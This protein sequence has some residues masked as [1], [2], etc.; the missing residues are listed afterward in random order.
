[1]KHQKNSQFSTE[2][3]W[4]MLFLY[5]N[6]LLLGG[7]FWINNREMKSCSLKSFANGALFICLYAFT[8][9]ALSGLLYSALLLIKC[10]NIYV[11]VRV[12][13]CDRVADL[14]WSFPCPTAIA[15][16]V[17][18]LVLISVGKHIIDTIL[19]EDALLALFHDIFYVAY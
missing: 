8:S 4:L 7:L 5:S 9:L 15:R 10:H 3:S 13:T 14:C 12:C 1:M 17:L 18:G 19:P 6:I 11:L 16:P 2:T